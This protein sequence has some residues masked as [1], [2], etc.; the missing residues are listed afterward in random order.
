MSMRL[1]DKHKCGVSGK[2]VHVPFFMREKASMSLVSQEE[3]FS[4]SRC[5]KKAG[6]LKIRVILGMC[7]SHWW[8]LKF[9]N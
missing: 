4:P 8:F 3:E 7:S 1:L 5:R 2:N 6:Y 9:N